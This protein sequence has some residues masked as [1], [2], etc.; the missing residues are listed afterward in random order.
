MPMLFFGAWAPEGKEDQP[1]GQETNSV[2]GGTLV[3]RRGGR[4]IDVS[5]PDVP[6]A[7]TQALRGGRPSR[8]RKRG[9]GGQQ[10]DTHTP[11][12]PDVPCFRPPFPAGP[13]CPSYPSSDG[14]IP[15]RVR[16]GDGSTLAGR[17]LHAPPSQELQMH[18]ENGLPG[19]LLAV[20]DQSIT[21]LIH[22]LIHGDLR[23][24]LEQPRYFGG[25][26][27]SHVV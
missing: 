20:Q 21:A 3:L 24:R 5:H 27:F 13:D 1:F 17:P 23:R 4:E 14:W 10:L 8:S 15:E 22:S 2:P 19:A 25:M 6:R 18:M 11:S 26:G 16:G 7:R 12:V 9:W